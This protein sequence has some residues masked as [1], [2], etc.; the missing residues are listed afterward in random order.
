MKNDDCCKDRESPKGIDVKSAALE[1]PKKLLLNKSIAKEAAEKPIHTSEWTSQWFISQEHWQI[2]G[3][4]VDFIIAASTTITT[5]FRA[6]VSSPDFLPFMR[7]VLDFIENIRGFHDYHLCVVPR[8]LIAETSQDKPNTSWPSG[9]VLR[10]AKKAGWY[11]FFACDMS[12]GKLKVPDTLSNLGIDSLIQY[13]DKDGAVV[14]LP[15]TQRDICVEER[16]HTRCF[17]DA[18]G[19]PIYVVVMRHNVRKQLELSD[20]ELEAFWLTAV[21]V[22]DK[23]HSAEDGSDLFEALQV[24]SGGFQN[25]A[26]L[27]LKILMRP[28]AFDSAWEHN[29]SYQ[30]LKRQKVLV[31]STPVCDLWCCY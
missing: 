16:M 13:R 25:L 17:M 8:V 26:H 14:K 18:K 1:T 19:R 21:Q 24:N 28:S 20:L 2:P 23:Y 22:L 12:K 30:I 11:I 31:K 4:K 29:E 27:H 7:S 3:T 6:F 9:S 15:L 5:T 10:A